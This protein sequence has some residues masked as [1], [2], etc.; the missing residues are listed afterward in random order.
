MSVTPQLIE[1]GRDSRRASEPTSE[2]TSYKRNCGQMPGRMRSITGQR[3]H[4]RKV[5]LIRFG[6]PITK[7]PS[8]GSA[9]FVYTIAKKGAGVSAAL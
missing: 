7:K 6:R 2:N 3:P 8:P 9:R 4:S 5:A 1:G